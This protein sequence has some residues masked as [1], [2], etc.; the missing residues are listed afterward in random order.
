MLA[1]GCGG[2]ILRFV[3]GSRFVHVLSGPALARRSV[4]G[5]GSCPFLSL[6]R[7][8]NS[9]GPDRL[10]AMGA[11]TSGGVGNFLGV[12]AAILKLRGGSIFEHVLRSCPCPALV[13]ALGGRCSKGRFLSA[14]AAIVAGIVLARSLNGYAT[15][16]L[17]GVGLSNGV[18]RGFVS[19]ER[20]ANSR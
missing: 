20:V 7:G 12:I 18:P 5:I 10:S 8:Y 15:D 16:G 19:F 13:T 1:V 4:F 3:S 17:V 6:T 11:V 9:V 14:T 2:V